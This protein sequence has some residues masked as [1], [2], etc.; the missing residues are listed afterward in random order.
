MFK[1]YI[2]QSTRKVLQILEIAVSELATLRQN[3]LTPDFI[4]SALLSQPDSEAVKI[5]EHV[6]DDVFETVAGINAQISRQH[7]SVAPVQ[8]SQI[9]ASQEV[10]AVFNIAYKEATQLGDQYISTGTLFIAM[11]DTRAGTTAEYL[12]SVGIN[13]KQ[14]RAVL[15]ELRGGR[16]VNGDDA[17]TQADA[18]AEYT[19]DLT[20]LARKGELDP[21]VGGEAEMSQVIQTLSRG[22]K[23]NPALI[24]EA[25][26][27][28]TVIVEGLAQLMVEANVPDTLLNK[29]LLSLDMGEIVAGAKMRGEFE[30]RLKGVRDAVIAAKGQVILFI[31]E[32]HTVV[33]V[34]AGAG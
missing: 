24:G 10:D 13:R 25:G 4:L 27:S 18:L 28:K 9:V 8:A 1:N 19:R 12:G 16:M 3:L 22:K 21:V 15:K 5:L 7:Q 23:N 17:E 29:R 2:K 11:F 14:A 20:E 33:G 32:L 34:G 26:V 30:E 31:D 6:V